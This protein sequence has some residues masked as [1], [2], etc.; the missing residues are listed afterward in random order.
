MTGSKTRYILRP[1]VKCAEDLGIAYLGR[2]GA[3]VCVVPLERQINRA[4]FGRKVAEAEG[5]I[6]TRFGYLEPIKASKG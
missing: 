5:G 6:F 1:S 4:E 2:P 3:S